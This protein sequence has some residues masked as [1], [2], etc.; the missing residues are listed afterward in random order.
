MHVLFSCIHLQIIFHDW[1]AIAKMIKEATSCS[2]TLKYQYLKYYFVRKWTELKKSPSMFSRNKLFLVC[3]WR[4]YLLLCAILVDITMFTFVIT[5][6]KLEMLIITIVLMI[7]LNSVTM[8]DCTLYV[9]KNQSNWLQLQ[10]THIQRL[11][12][13]IVSFWP[14]WTSGFINNECFESC[15]RTWTFLTSITCIPFALR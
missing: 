12:R 9:L 10:S 1:I 7:M 3:I 11:V 13:L 8:V 14:M 6:N 4:Q 5:R 15:L 2:H